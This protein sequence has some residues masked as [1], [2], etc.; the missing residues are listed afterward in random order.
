MEGLGELRGR[1]RE[2][3]SK[4]LTSSWLALTKVF[5]FYAC[6]ELHTISC[7]SNI[8]RR[9]QTPLY[10]ISPRRAPQTNR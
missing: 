5:N 6:S 1:E 9:L 10:E 8:L 4:Y 2:R 3:A 7:P